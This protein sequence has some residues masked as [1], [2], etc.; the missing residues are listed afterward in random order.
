MGWLASCASADLLQM[1]YW[2]AVFDEGQNG[3]IRA[4]V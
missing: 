2:L 1:S 4:V 3:T